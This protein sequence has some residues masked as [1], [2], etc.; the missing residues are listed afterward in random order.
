VK[1]S[2]FNIERRQ[3]RYFVV[4]LIFSFNRVEVGGAGS[5]LTFTG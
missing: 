4:F 2:R 5:L 1:L 3:L